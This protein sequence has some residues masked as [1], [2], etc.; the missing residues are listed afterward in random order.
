MTLWQVRP[1][2]AAEE[3]HE[4]GSPGWTTFM[5]Q[6]GLA[7]SLLHRKLLDHVPAAEL[8][9]GGGRILEVGAGA[10]RIALELAG[11]TGM[12]SDAC[13][14]NGAAMS[15]LGAELPGTRCRKVEA[16]PPLPYADETFDA[17]YAISFL[18]R[19]GEAESIAWLVEFARTLKPE[20]AALVSLRGPAAVALEARSALEG[21]SAVT[22]A[23][24]ESAGMIAPAKP[25]GRL[26]AHSHAYVI[27][28]FGR[29]LAVEAIYPGV[30]GA[31]ED[32]L[33]L[34]KQLNSSTEAK[35]PDSPKHMP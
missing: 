25:E 7:A 14:V 19:L 22:V 1:E 27:D 3:F 15:Y 18:P 5:R 26:A 4:A 8:A 29:T 35:M 23:D 31:R 24:L 34:R 28:V 21:T 12:P 9:S 13:D 10:G 11:R 16:A 2:K 32:L 20:G 17:L 6:G 33:V 30:V